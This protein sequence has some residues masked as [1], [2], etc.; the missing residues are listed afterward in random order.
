M[1]NFDYDS[2]PIGYY[3]SVYKKRKGIQSAWHHIKFDFVEKQVGDSKNHLD[4]GCGS[5]TFLGNYLKDKKRVGIDIVKKQ[6]EFANKE[7]KDDKTSFL[8]YDKSILPFND[9]EF[10]TISLIEIIEHLNED[11]TRNLINE[12]KRC[13]KDNGHIVLTTPNYLSFWPLLEIIL[14][15][16]SNV[17]YEHQHISKYNYFSLKKFIKSFNLEII[18]IGTF[19]TIS[20][21]VAFISFK[22]SKFLSKLNFFNLNF[23]FLI[24]V[25]I[26]KI[27]W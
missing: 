7:N 19:M 13:L 9:N 25:K 12:S 8:R 16:F 4:I 3:D 2:I 14:N 24:Y 27:T 21:F 11:D 18:E 15:K 5:G 23:G 22:L 6:I 26:K 1:A 10:D 20:P 17:N